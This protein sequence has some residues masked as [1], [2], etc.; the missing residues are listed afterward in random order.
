MEKGKDSLDPGELAALA[1]DVRV[2]LRAARDSL[3]GEKARSA[4]QKLGESGLYGYD[5]AIGEFD[6]DELSSNI[7]VME[8]TISLFAKEMAELAGK[9]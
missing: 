3:N 9:K 1:N 8:A 7:F 5:G 4:W 2:A 6:L